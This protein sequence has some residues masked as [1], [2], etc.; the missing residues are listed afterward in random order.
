MGP[1]GFKPFSKDEIERGIEKGKTIADL[2]KDREEKEIKFTKDPEASSDPVITAMQER[3]KAQAKKLSLDFY[4]LIKKL[5]PE[6]DAE[7]EVKKLLEGKDI[8]GFP[9]GDS[10]IAKLARV[11]T[12]LEKIQQERKTQYTREFLMLAEEVSENLENNLEGIQQFIADNY[13]KNSMNID[14]DNKIQETIDFFEDMK[15]KTSI[16]ESISAL[17]AD[18]PDKQ[19]FLPENNP[20]YSPDKVFQREELVEK[21][22]RITGEVSTMQEQAVGKYAAIMNLLNAKLLN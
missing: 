16:I 5:Y 19:F 20:N 7:E 11:A 18:D 17:L 6:R 1:E 9:V 15:D 14:L 3:N 8:D 13:D 2:K 12:E 22:N 21:L 10:K 4:K